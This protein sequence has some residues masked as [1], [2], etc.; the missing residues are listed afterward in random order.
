MWLVPATC[1]RDNHLDDAWC[2]LTLW[3]VACN[4]PVLPNGTGNELPI[5]MAL[6]GRPTICL[7]QS[8]HSDLSDGHVTWGDWMCMLCF[9]A[10]TC[11]MNLNWFEFM[12]QVAASNCIKTYMSHEVTCDGDILPHVT[13]PLASRL[14]MQVPYC[15]S[16]PTFLDLSSMSVMKWRLCSWARCYPEFSF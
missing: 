5:K 7:L 9:V 1:V 16:S 15:M 4:T 11:R 13:G 8:C 3:H 2:D 14:Q 6:Q 10:A 12:W